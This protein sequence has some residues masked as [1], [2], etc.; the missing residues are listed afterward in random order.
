VT[1]DVSQGH[2]PTTHWSV[3]LAA[4]EDSSPRAEAALE[5]L[6]R[7]YWYPLYAYARRRGYSPEDAEDLTQGFFG[8][9]LERDLLAGLRPAGA[10]F[11]SFLLHAF[12]NHLASEWVRAHAAKRGGT[13]AVISLH[14]LDLEARYAREA[15]DAETPELL[16]E[17]RWANAVLQRALDRLRE[18]HIVAG[19]EM[20]FN[21]LVNCLTMSAPSQPYGHLAIQLGLSEGAL[22]MNIHRLRRRYGELL[23][24][25][26]A[27]TVVTPAEIDHE[28]KYLLGILA[29]T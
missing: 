25:E 3:I 13:N 15:H 23:R 8:R 26:I 12:K 29:T 2:F 4:D 16:F 9:L 11:R 6:C 1:G 24:L 21:S 27:Q 14:E 17:R 18:E 19:K 5:Q 7:D 22:K 28:L 10:R 20:L